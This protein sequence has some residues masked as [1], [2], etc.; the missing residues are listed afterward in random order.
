MNQDS[1]L[2]IKEKLA[3]KRISIANLIV[4]A[5]DYGR[6]KDPAALDTA[7]MAVETYTKEFMFGKSAGDRATL[8]MIEKAIARIENGTYGSCAHCEEPIQPKRL[9]AIP[10]ALYCIGCQQLL[11]KGA[12]QN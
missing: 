5:G 7:D 12:L 11:E 4:R 9:E 10:W 6:E 3:E 1:L 2:R 8:Q